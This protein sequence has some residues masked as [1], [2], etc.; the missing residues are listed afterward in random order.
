[1]YQKRTIVFFWYFY[2]IKSNPLLRLYI[3]GGG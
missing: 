1:M 3:V 2:N